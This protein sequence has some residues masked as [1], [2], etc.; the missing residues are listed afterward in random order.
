MRLSCFSLRK[1]LRTP[2]VSSKLKVAPLKK[3]AARMRFIVVN[4]L[5]IMSERYGGYES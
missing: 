4:R 2:H 3:K 5:V 1:R